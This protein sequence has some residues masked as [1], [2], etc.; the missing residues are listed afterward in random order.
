MKTYK[1]EKIKVSKSI[2]RRK[3]WK[4]FGAAERDPPGPNPAN[5]YISEEVQMQFVH[6]KDAVC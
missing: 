4:K 6:G 3:E 1:I 2:A 5:T